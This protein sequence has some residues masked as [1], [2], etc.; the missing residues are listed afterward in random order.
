MTVFPAGSMPSSLSTDWETFACRVLHLHVSFRTILSNQSN[1]LKVG[2]NS[3][4]GKNIN[5]Q[6]GLIMGREV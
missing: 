6:Y 3:T 4:E 5:G 2:G 1:D